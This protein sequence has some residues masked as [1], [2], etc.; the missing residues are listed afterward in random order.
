MPISRRPAMRTAIMILLLLT[1]TAQA[2][3]SRY[4]Q[5]GF[6]QIP[7]GICVLEQ[8]RRDGRGRDRR[9]LKFAH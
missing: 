5:L 1:G 4:C 9:P 7:H 8:L 2:Q 3:P 6:G